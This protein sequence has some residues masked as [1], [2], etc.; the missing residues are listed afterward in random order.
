MYQSRTRIVS[1]II[2]IGFLRGKITEGNTDILNKQTSKWGQNHA[3]IC[4]NTQKWV[5]AGGGERVEDQRTPT[6]WL[7]SLRKRAEPINRDPMGKSFPDRKQESQTGDLTDSR[8]CINPFPRNC[9][10]GR[11]TSSAWSSSSSREQAGRCYLKRR[12]LSLLGSH[13]SMTGGSWSWLGPE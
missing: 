12:S 2:K 6:I 1:V 5:C 10:R 11:L 8:H 13:G 7:K 9:P 4:G 3:T